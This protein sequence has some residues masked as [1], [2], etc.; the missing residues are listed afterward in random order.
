MFY[1]DSSALVKLVIDEAESGALRSFLRAGPITSSVIARVEVP[2]AVRRRGQD[3]ERLIP[4]VLSRMALIDMAVAI[5]ARA[6]RLDP[7][8]LRTLDAIHLAS[9]MELGDDLEAIVTYDA[10]MLAA[11]ELMRLPVAAPA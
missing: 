10:R 2:R 9:A 8:V 11:A 5:I 7:P 3:Y 4:A 6:A 1:L